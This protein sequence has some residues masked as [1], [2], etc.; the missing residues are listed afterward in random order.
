MIWYQGK[1]PGGK[2][3]WTHLHH[4][5]K[6][7]TEHRSLWNTHQLREVSNIGCKNCKV[8]DTWACLHKSLHPTSACYT[9]FC[10]WIRT[11]TF[12]GQTNNNFSPPTPPNP[13]ALR[14]QGPSNPAPRFWARRRGPISDA[15]GRSDGASAH[16]LH[17]HLGTV[18]WPGAEPETS[19][20][21]EFLFLFE[22]SLISG[23][24]EQT[25]YTRTLQQV[26]L[27]GFQIAKK[28][29]KSTCWKVY[30]YFMCCL[31]RG[32]SRV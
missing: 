30:R 2:T 12:L 19:G 17:P 7:W 26:L 5:T 3:T 29:T 15:L 10:F 28:P 6:L 25:E 20:Q 4:F 11:S 1:K 31:Q 22:M 9:I 24:D 16:G 18:H 13:P 32:I 8:L 27:G 14:E 21:K 23:K